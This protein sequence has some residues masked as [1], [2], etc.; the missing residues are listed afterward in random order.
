M[1]L[2]FMLGSLPWQGLKAPTREQRYRLVLEKK[3]TT[4]VAELCGDL[5]QE[6]AIY[7]NY[8]RNL[9]HED[10]PDYGY[11]RRIFRNLFWRQRFEYDHVFDWTTREYQRQ[12]VEYAE[13]SPATRNTE[14]MRGEERSEQSE[15]PSRHVA[16]R[17]RKRRKRT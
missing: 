17:R 11:L 10:K 5:P 12:N 7:M 14:M 15:G 1:M 4:S 2:Y 3:Q 6:F 9:R 8:V 13:Q 16:K